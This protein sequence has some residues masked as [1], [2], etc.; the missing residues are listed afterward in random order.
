MTGGEG[1]ARTSVLS[2]T[3][4]EPKAEDQDSAARIQEAIGSG[5]PTLA[6]RLPNG[7]EIE[8]STALVKILLASA[9]ELLAGHTITVL[10]SETDLT[11]NEVGKLLGLSR[12]YVARLLDAGEIPSRNIPG[13]RHR[14]ISL[15]DV[16]AFQERRNRRR[17]GRAQLT[18]A[19]DEAGLPY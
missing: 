18:K 11:P 6:L 17:R 8:L 3:T 12:P 1:V 15:S 13:S 4:I 10:A 19:I 7:Q 9:G 5:N 16:L 2:N 14:L